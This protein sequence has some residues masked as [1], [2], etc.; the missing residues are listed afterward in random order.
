MALPSRRSG[1]PRTPEGRKAASHNA[2]KTGAYAQTLLPGEPREAYEA[3]EN[4]LLADYAPTDVVS[5][6]LVSNLAGLIWKKM[7]L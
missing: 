3:V 7:R 2:L 1:D 5:E 6:M 4:A